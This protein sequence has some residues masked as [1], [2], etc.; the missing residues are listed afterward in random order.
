M[1]KVLLDSNEIDKLIIYAL[2]EDI[3]S[4]DV[5][6][7]NIVDEFQQS[8]GRLTAKS[9]GVI[10]GLGIAKR[11]FDILESLTLWIAH[12]E[13][14]DSV[15][16]GDIIVEFEGYLKPMLKAERTALNFLQRMS[17][18]ATKT[19]RY[20]RLLHG[21]NTRILDTRKTVPGLRMLDKY[22]VSCGGGVNHRIGLY[23][24]VM[25]KDN[26]IKAAGNI[27]RAVELVKANI[28]P[29]IRIEVETSNMKEVK[30]ALAAGI[31]VIMLDNMTTE[32]MKEAVLFIDGK[33]EIEASGNMTATRLVDTAETG[34]DFISVGAL[35]HSVEAL[36]ISMLLQ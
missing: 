20:V 13:D 16:A 32:Q 5:T 1:N 14:G 29:N 11:V 27:S 23:D 3:G 4:G 36:D 26:H 33:V 18:I 6:T 21:Y 2:Q 10:A 22:A 19:S 30:E 17:G 31:D 15:K 8:K 24:M 35:T 28:K 9:D 34:V 7:D 25:I 12:F